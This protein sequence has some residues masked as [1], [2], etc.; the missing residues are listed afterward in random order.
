VIGEQA[1][2]LRAGITLLKQDELHDYS[3]L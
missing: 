3:S 2:Q 1:G